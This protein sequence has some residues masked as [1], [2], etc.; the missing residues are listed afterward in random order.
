MCWSFL[1][2]AVLQETKLCCS[3]EHQGDPDS[4]PSIPLRFG[5]SSEVLLLSSSVQFLPSTQQQ[6]TTY[7]LTLLMQPIVKH[8]MLQLPSN[9]T[10]F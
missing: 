8:H 2:E 1:S 7:L 9:L 10:H 4:P 6:K 3:P 5:V